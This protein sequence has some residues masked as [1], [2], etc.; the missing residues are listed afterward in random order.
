MD[1][2]EIIYKINSN[3]AKKSM[4]PRLPTLLN[5]KINVH[6]LALTPAKYHKKFFA[7]ISSMKISFLGII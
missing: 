2:Y 5:N 6:Q 1:I 3:F 7:E 4:R